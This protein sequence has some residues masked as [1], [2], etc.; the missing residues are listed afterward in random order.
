[1]DWTAFAFKRALATKIEAAL[2]D[3]RV[4]TYFVNPDEEGLNDVIMVGHSLTDTKAQEKL[5]GNRHREDVTV[6]CQ[7]R[8]I[9]YGAG[10]TTAQAAEDRAVALLAEIDEIVRTD[11]P[12][13]GDQTLSATLASRDAGLFAVVS[14]EG[15]AARVCLIDFTIQYRADTS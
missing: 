6:E 9:E 7:L 12:Q 8:S 4:V 11:A 15:A 2:P 10:E 13:V 3:E 5:G 14:Q 1:M